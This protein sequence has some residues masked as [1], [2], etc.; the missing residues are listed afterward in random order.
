MSS[1]DFEHSPEHQDELPEEAES[2]AIVPPEVVQELGSIATAP[3][4]EIA[5]EPNPKPAVPSP[6]MFA[7]VKK[8]QEVKVKTIE[9]VVTSGT[10]GTA[11]T[12]QTITSI[13]HGQKGIM[14]FHS[15]INLVNHGRPITEETVTSLRQELRELKDRGEIVEVSKNQYA[16]VSALNDLPRKVPEHIIEKS[17]QPK[18]ANELKTRQIKYPITGRRRYE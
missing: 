3:E 12:A 18:T 17:R 14:S 5:E 7:G 11:N 9:E 15:I 6:L 8:P 10:V 4:A 13:I 16:L 2:L 1:L